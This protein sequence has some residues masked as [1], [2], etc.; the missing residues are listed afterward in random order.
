MVIG[1]AF[2]SFFRETYHSSSHEG[3][4]YQ[5]QIEYR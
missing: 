1:M 4:N 5:L 3:E 2:A